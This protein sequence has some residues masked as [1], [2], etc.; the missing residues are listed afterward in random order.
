MD[1]RTSVFG[2]APCYASTMVNFMHRRH[3]VLAGLLGIGL[4][5]AGFYPDQAMSRC[6]SDAI[7]SGNHGSPNTYAVAKH[8]APNATDSKEGTAPDASEEQHVESADADN[9]SAGVGGGSAA[10]GG[11]DATGNL[12][13][14]GATPGTH[15]R[16]LRWQ[17]FLPG[18]IK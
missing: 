7:G 9:R 10:P 12:G 6:D 15:K 4:V 13:G 17:S 8:T 5:S 1:V 18:V 2:I 3:V 14:G 16:G 11:D